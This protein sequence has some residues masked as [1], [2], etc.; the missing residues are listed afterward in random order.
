LLNWAEDSGRIDRSPFPKR[1]MPRVHESAPKGLSPDEIA[2]LVALHEP[3]GFTLRFLLGTGVRWSEACRAQRSHIE[4]G[5]LV[6]ENTK[7]T[8]VRRVRLE[9]EL[10]AEVE[11]RVGR[12]VPFAEGNPGGFARAVRRMTGI[13]GFHVHRTRHTFAMGWLAH[14]GSL[15]ALQEVL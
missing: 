8:R 4:D 1:V 5:R 14:K 7:G 3:Y 6:L 15:A 11:G 12:L 13:E 2:K 9:P 10:L